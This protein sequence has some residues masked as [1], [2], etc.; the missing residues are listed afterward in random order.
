MGA[1]EGVADLFHLLSFV[2]AFGSLYIGTPGVGRLK[3]TAFGVIAF[4]LVLGIFALGLLRPDYPPALLAALFLFL[5]AAFIPWGTVYQALLAIIAVC[6]PPIAQLLGYSLHPDADAYWAVRGGPTAFWDELLATST[7]LTLLAVLSVVVTRTLYNLRQSA[8]RAERLGNYVIEAKLGEGGMAE[9]YLARHARMVQPS[10]VK[11][12]RLSDQVSEDALARFERE[13]HL[14]SN[15]THPNTITI[16]DFGRADR[17]TFYFAMEYLDGID[18]HA[19]VERHGPLPASRVVFILRQVCGSLTEAHASNIIHRDLK[20]SNIFLTSR[21][22]LYDF[23]K[24][25]DFG[26][27]KQAGAET[28]DEAE[29]ADASELTQMGQVFGTPR[30]MSPEQWEDSG[31]ADPR[32][33]IYCLGAVAYHLLTARPPFVS[34]SPVQLLIDHAKTLPEPPS[35]VTELPIP[36]ELDAIVMRCLEK[37]P[38]HRF[39]SVEELEAALGEVPFDEPWTRESA[40]AWWELHEPAQEVEPASEASAG[41]VSGPRMIRPDSW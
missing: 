26:L 7:G 11:V 37:R 19:L 22:G 41:K 24:V 31:S 30:Y 1:W 38:E 39:Q 3:G 2:L 4:N 6:T 17:S 36:S 25:L 40:R 34:S 28:G 21:G 15:L 20:P 33:D 29:R 23:V 13:I 35:H 27:A 8:R 16:R 18:L 10:A 5:P 32:S 9:V 12:L 14:A